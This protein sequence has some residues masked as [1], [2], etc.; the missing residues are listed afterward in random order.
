MITVNHVYK[1]FDQLSVLEDINVTFKDHKTYAIIGSSG[2]GKS[3][4]LRMLNGLEVPTKGTIDI[5]GVDIV[6]HHKQLEKLRPEI[7]MVFQSFNLFEHKTALENVMFAL[8]KVKKMSEKQAKEIAISKL[9][10]VG[11]DHRL[12]H[13]PH[14][15]S[16]GEKQRVAI[17]RALAMSP[18]ILL[19][20]E[21][22][23]ALDPE[24]TVEVLNVIK[25]VT[26]KKLTS[27]LVTH[28]MNFAKEV[29]DVIVY[30]DKG[31]IIE[32]A[33]TTTFFTNTQ[34]ERAIQFLNNML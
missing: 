24:M 29:A 1:S 6:K 15:L 14:T 9:K 2:S 11:C 22:T 32:V 26:K 16:G 20:D 3:T 28:E 33:D 27:I 5:D 25:Q 10:E 30:M 19:F 4:L 12:D 17:A 21:P 34:S 23:S 13:Y 18:S 7:G 31:Q 8:V